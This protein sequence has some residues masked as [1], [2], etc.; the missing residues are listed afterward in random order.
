MYGH[1]LLLPVP[2]IDRTVVL[3]GLRR[4][5][6]G[7]QRLADDRARLPAPAARA[8]GARRPD[9]RRRPAPHRDRQGR[10]RAPLR[11]AGHR[12]VRA[13]GDAARA[14]RRGPR[15]TPPA[16]V[17]G[18]DAVRA[19]VADFTPERAE[20][21]SGMPRRRRPRGS[22]ASSR[23]P[24]AAAATAGSGS[25]RRRSARSATWAV[26]LPQPAHRQPRP[27]GRRDVHPTRPSTWSAAARSAAATTTSGAAGCAACRSSAASCPVATLRRGDRDARRGQVRAMLTLAGNPVL[28]TPDGARLGRALAA[29]TSWRR[30]TSTST[31]PPGT[32]T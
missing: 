3:P 24:T 17:D 15:P 9:G 27:A 20:A 28:S 2:D 26:Q 32:P 7:L 1:Q 8:E 6:D 5:P 19:A 12:R 29:W 16:Y 18:L 25:P 21:V 23:P 13:A 4:Q 22:P 30:S 14:V 10:R 31:R 11:P